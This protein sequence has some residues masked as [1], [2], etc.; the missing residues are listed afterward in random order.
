[1][2]E[3]RAGSLER[4][5][6]RR[7]AAAHSGDHSDDVRCA[8]RY[9]PGLR[10]AGELLRHQAIGSGRIPAGH[11][12]VERFLSDDCSTAAA[13]GSCK[14]GRESLECKSRLTIVRRRRLPGR[15]SVSSGFFL[16]FPGA[17]TSNPT[18]PGTEVAR[19]VFRR[20]RASLAPGPVCL[21]GPCLLPAS[22]PVG[23]PV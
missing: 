4:N 5:Q 3:G 18:P 8:Q 12:H 22:W 19:L 23:R 9:C 2:A 7:G 20:P 6:S 11:E 14:P 1:M 13:H 15:E 16:P 17:D 21:L 10:V